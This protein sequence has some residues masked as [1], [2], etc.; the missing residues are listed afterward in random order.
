VVRSKEEPAT[1]IRYDETLR[2]QNRY[3]DGRSGRLLG[4][5]VMPRKP[6][7]ET[8]MTD[9]ERQARYRAARA[10]GV[11]VARVL[12]RRPRWRWC[13]EC[14]S[15]SVNG[16]SDPARRHHYLLIMATTTD[17]FGFDAITLKGRS[18]DR[19]RAALRIAHL[20][21]GL[22]NADTKSWRLKDGMKS[23]CV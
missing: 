2:K 19:A 11:P 21:V 16:S 3:S 13:G 4:V 12:R 1:N 23:T 5:E 7:G 20:H 10:T 14:R 15:D 18:R 9:A 8:A 17:F 22:A 6:I